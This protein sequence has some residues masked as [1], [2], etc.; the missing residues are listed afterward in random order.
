MN[1]KAVEVLLVLTEEQKTTKELARSIGVTYARASQVVKLLLQQGFVVRTNGLIRLADTAQAVLL[2]KLTSRF[3]LKKLLADSN[4]R[5]AIALLDPV[6]LADVER[7][8]SLSYWTV[9]RSLDSLM[10]IGAATEENGKYRLVEDEELRLFLRLLEESRHKALAEPYSEVVLSAKGVLLKEVPLGKK[11]DGSLTAFSVFSKHGMDIRP[12]RQYLVQ[13]AQKVAIEDALIHALVFSKT[14]VDLTDCAV[15]YAKNRGSLDS[16]RLRELAKEFEVLDV[17]TDLKGYVSNLTVPQP[18]RFLPWEE[19][20]EKARLYGISP[21]DLVPKP[22][23]PDFVEKLGSAIRSNVNLFVFGGEAMRVRGLKRATKDIDVVVDDPA[24]LRTL[25]EALASMGYRMLGG[26]EMSNADANLDPSGIFVSEEH[27]RID[28]FVR[29]ICGKFRLSD[30]MKGRSTCE[31]HARLNFCVM[32]NE[33]V[34]L[35]KSVTDREGDVYDMIELAK[36][37]GFR[38][39]I[40]LEELYQQEANTNARFCLGL[41][42][43]LEIIQERANIRAPFYNKL[44]NH[45]IDHAILNAVGQWNAKTIPQVR[46]F[47][48]YPDYRLRNRIEKLVKEGRLVK[49]GGEL[50]SPKPAD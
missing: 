44:V 12:V 26:D 25:R 18:Q 30:S 36:A 5:V 3:D 48:D 24:E 40:V 41:L 42:D 47:V 35:L 4:E 13:P 7:R 20:A 9:K 34:F 14:P 38:W 39:Q 32:S 46:R 28:I 22:A 17:F 31:R 11:A 45:C 37:Q 21:E 10:Q 27:P 1:P 2:R 29:V 43:S 8:T 19:F 49:R 6:S 23:Y 16:E 33:D 15:F 50:E